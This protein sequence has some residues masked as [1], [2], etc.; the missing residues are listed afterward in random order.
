MRFFMLVFGILRLVSLLIECSCIAPRTPAVIGMRGK[1]SIPHFVGFGLMGHIWY[2]RLR[3]R[4]WSG[5]LSWQY[6]SS[7]SW[8]VSV[9]VSF[10]HI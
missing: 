10:I 5:N 8:T 7:I 9:S 2:V 1:F 4:A 3:F 6:V